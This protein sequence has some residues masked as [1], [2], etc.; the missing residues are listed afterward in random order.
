MSVPY[1]LCQKKDRIPSEESR[2][3]YQEERL[4]KGFPVSL[5]WDP[6]PFLARSTQ[7]ST[8]VSYSRVNEALGHVHMPVLWSVFCISIKKP[9][10]VGPKLIHVYYTFTLQNMQVWALFFFC[11]QL[12]VYFIAHSRCKVQNKQHIRCF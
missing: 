3:T 5:S 6:I 7:L 4:E 2:E 11:A 1:I 12:L 8:E 10:P 9:R